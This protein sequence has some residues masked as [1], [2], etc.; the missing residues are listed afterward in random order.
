[1]K[2]I[3]QDCPHCGGKGKYVTYENE[4]SFCH[5]CRTLDIGKPTTQ[6][7]FL[8]RRDPPG[9]VE[10]PEDFRLIKKGD[11]G[12]LYLITQAQN[13]HLSMR[14]NT[15]SQRCR[16]NLFGHLKEYIGIPPTSSFL[17]VWSY[18]LVSLIIKTPL[19]PW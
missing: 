1:M 16:N 9:P 2:K 8:P 19:Q 18:N 11:V 15:L 7:K 12:W 14:L 13:P 17:M 10:L 3:R 5:R 4:K 6:K